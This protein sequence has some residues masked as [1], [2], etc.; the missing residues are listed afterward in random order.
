[1]SADL[2]ALAALALGAV[3]GALTGALRQLAGLA[4]MAAAALLGPRLAPLL[5]RPAAALVPG[6]AARPLAGL[7]GF[8]LVLVVATLVAHLLVRLAVGDERPPLD[9]AGGALLGGAKSAA[10]LWAL[11][12]LL[13]LWDRPVGPKGFRLDPAEGEA[14]ALV[15]EHNLYDLVAP[16]E[17]RLLRERLPALRDQVERLEKRVR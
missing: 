5:E 10:G 6:A 14:M 9:R 2:L 3:A 1:M 12:S 11:L 15:R 17:A 4:A 8:L 13:A 16:A 7:A